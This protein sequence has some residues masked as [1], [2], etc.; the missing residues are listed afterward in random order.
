MVVRFGGGKPKFVPVEL[1][2]DTVE[3]IAKEYDTTESDLC[4]LNSSLKEVD[5]EVTYDDDGEQRSTIVRTILVDPGALLVVP[6]PRGGKRK[7]HTVRSKEILLVRPPAGDVLKDFADMADIVQDKEMTAE[8]AG[9]AVDGMYEACAR[10]L[11]VNMQHRRVTAKEAYAK[12][13][14]EDL[15]YLLRTIS[16][17][18]IG[19]MDDPN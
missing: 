5:T 16:G 3:S 7:Q 13:D 11:S 6:G 1:P 2:G 15:G 19:A 8:I 12:L 10:M 17:Q 9:K 4:K 14:I 18:V